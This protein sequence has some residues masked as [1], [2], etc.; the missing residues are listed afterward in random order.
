MLN[1]RVNIRASTADQELFTHTAKF[2]ARVRIKTRK[3][4]FNRRAHA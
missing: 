4:S 3:S 1:A 2:M